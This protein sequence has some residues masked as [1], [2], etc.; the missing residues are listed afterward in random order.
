MNELIHYLVV[1]EEC[2]AR[3]E[4]TEEQIESRILPAMK[5]IAQ[6]CAGYG[7]HFNYPLPLLRTN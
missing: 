5:N 3:W 6:Q 7:E 1:T 2:Q 4:P